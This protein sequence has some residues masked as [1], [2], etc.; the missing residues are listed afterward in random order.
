[1]PFLGSSILHPCMT[2]PRCYYLLYVAKEWLSAYET[3]LERVSAM[4]AVVGNACFNPSSPKEALGKNHFT[5]ISHM[6]ELE[7]VR[8]SSQCWG[9]NQSQLICFLTDERSFPKTSRLSPTVHPP[10][11]CGMHPGRGCSAWQWDC[12]H[13]Q[14]LLHTADYQQVPWAIL[15]NTRPGLDK[16]RKT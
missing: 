7:M 16:E 10:L 13:S 9:E 5:W 14:A 11:L 12:I 3:Q 8:W 6:Y 15:Q 2:A 1:M 4:T